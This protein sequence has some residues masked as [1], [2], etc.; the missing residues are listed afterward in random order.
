MSCTLRLQIHWIIAVPLLALLTTL[1]FSALRA[2]TFQGKALL[3]AYP[4]FSLW[5]AIGSLAG[6]IPMSVQE[7]QPDLVLPWM[8][9]ITIVS[10]TASVLA[11]A[12]LFIWARRAKTV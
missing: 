3:A 10:V 9:V 11:R 2:R 12:R 6:F 5:A 7:T 4:L 1:F 8:L